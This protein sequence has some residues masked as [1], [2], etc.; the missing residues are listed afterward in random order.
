M[1]YIHLK[2][3]E[4]DDK[5]EDGHQDGRLAACSGGRHAEGVV[6]WDDVLAR[7]RES[8]L[9]L[10][11]TQTRNEFRPFWPACAAKN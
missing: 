6:V 3:R 7:R 2:A 10:F 8:T 5:K 4:N 11:H 9:N 1:K